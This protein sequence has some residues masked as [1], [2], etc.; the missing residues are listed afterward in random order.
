MLVTGATGFIGSHLCVELI[1]RGLKVTGLSRM[2]DTSDFSSHAASGN[3]NFQIVNCDILKK[4]DLIKTIE[5]I[6]SI[7]CIFHLAGQTFSRKSMDPEIY[8]KTNFMGT[9]NVLDCCRIFNIK[10]FIFSSSI[11]VYGLSEGQFLPHYLP[12]DEMHEAKPYEFYDL[13]KYH[14]EQICNFYSDRYGI[15][16]VVLRYSRV[17]GPGMK[18]GIVSTAITNA[19]SNSPIQ[20]SGDISTDFVF[21]KDVAESNIISFEKL[22]EG[23]HLFNIGSGQEIT[24]YEICS[25]IVEIA[26]SSS[27][28]YVNKEKKSR[29]SL[30]VS[31]AKKILSYQPT[32]IEQGLKE[33]VNHFK[34]SKNGI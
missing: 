21:V 7:D 11:A 5:K 13:S 25:K 2:V 16:C 9:L 31:K 12:V 18:G 32:T 20:I 29:F 3:E 8:F 33:C 17:F 34:K 26:S 14:A 28:I 1:K 6:G 23:F 19:M 30:N 27:K 22:S 4:S 15:S 10:K 24:L